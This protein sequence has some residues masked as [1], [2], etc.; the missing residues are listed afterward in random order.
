MPL[1]TRRI[2]ILAAAMATIGN[3]PAY[4]AEPQQSFS[5]SHADLEYDLDATVQLHGGSFDSDSSYNAGISY[6]VHPSFYVW[7]DHADANYDLQGVDDLWLTNTSLGIGYRRAS[8]EATLPMDFFAAVAYERQ[9][10]RHE[11]AGVVSVARYHGGSL[12]L[13][14]RAALTPQ[15]EVNMNA[16]QYI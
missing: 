2:S 8:R 6:L 5:Y 16:R 10:T 9:Q 15:L 12:Q 11:S 7:G 4:A 14:L 3:V 13:G 1:A